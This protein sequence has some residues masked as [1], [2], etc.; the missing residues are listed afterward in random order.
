MREARVLRGRSTGT[1]QDGAGEEAGKGSG[2]D[3]VP[4]P[5]VARCDTCRG[6]GGG[7]GLYVDC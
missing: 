2:D 4:G 3:A 5:A 1:G 6:G 7:V